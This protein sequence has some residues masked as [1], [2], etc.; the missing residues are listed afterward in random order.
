[1]LKVLE[2][3]LIILLCLIPPALLT[4]PFLPDFFLSLS[5]IIFLILC[6]VKKDFKY[7]KNIFFY[8]L[9]IFY[10]YICIISLFADNFYY[11][12]GSALVYIRYIVFS[13]STWYLIDTNKNI[14][15]H[16]FISITI[17]FIF[18]IASGYS[19]YIFDINYFNHQYDGKRLSGI[20]GEELILGSFLVR[21][22]PIF[23]ALL[24]LL[25]KKQV[26]F[27]PI[28]IISFLLI[29]NLVFLTGERSAFFYIVLINILSILC[30]NKII[31]IRIG[32]FA[33]SLLLIL[34]I[35]FNDS[36]VKERMIDDTLDHLNISKKY[37]DKM[38]IFSPAHESIILTS[39]KIYKDNK[40]FGIGV[41]MFREECK[42]PE[43]FDEVGCRNHPHN[44]YVQL[45]TE[46]GIAGFMFFL[47]IFVYI[48]ILLFWQFIKAI[49]KRNFSFIAFELTNYQICLLFAI[50]I[51]LWPFMPTGNFFHNWLNVIY[52]L[53]VGF[54]LSS[55]RYD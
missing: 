38:V 43:Y 19:Q 49:F 37:G 35:I 36:K 11:S 40:F 27:I 1:M 18:V 42:K 45:I 53:P 7:F 22:F 51:T 21:L 48:S 46:T 26:I 3:T 32:I 16:F 39:L 30:L 52:Y 20:F 8:S 5:S 2:N 10:L 55:R 29:N 54:I 14:L 24:F 33:S 9:G 31:I 50:F 25:I 6:F 47:A 44:T 28:F 23:L 34:L 17:T 41:K 13:L 15:K 12:F 4:G